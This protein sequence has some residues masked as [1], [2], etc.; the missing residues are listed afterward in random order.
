[1]SDRAAV[2]EFLLAID[3]ATPID[4]LIASAGITMVTPGAG[5]VEDLIKSAELFD[6]N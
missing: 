1:M 5:A 2:S 4:C 3:A 6:V